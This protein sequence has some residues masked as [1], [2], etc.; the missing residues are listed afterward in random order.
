ME[1]YIAWWNVENL[2]DVNNSPDRPEWLQ[3]ALKSEL[4]GWTAAVLDSKLKQLAHVITA[5]NDGKGPDMLGVCE[6]ENAA[7]LEK[8]LAKLH[9][10]LPDR[11]YSIEHHDASDQRGIDVAFIYDDSLF[12]AEMQFHR[13]ILKRYAT[14]DLFQVNFRMK[15]N[16]L[17][18]VVLGNHWPS[19]SGGR[20]ESE[21]Y[22][23]MAAET[24]SYWIDRTMHHVGDDTPILVMGDFNDTP[25]DRSMTDYALSTNSRLKVSYSRSPRLYN[26]MHFLAGQEKGTHYFNNFPSV[27]DQFLINKALMTGAGGVQ[28]ISGPDGRRTNADIFALP[29]MQSS[30]RYKSPVRFGRPSSVLNKAGFSD[31]YPI[32]IT[33]KSPD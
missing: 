13:V 32:T 27:L 17:P 31:H 24:L 33:L 1:F 5:M 18:L 26:P 30:G 8:L 25:T 12:K 3:K 28:P 29:E 23:I 14:R 19:R 4:K 16:Q 15:H 22:R 11:S 9:K 10:A 20:Y 7:V 21:P 2:F 6:V